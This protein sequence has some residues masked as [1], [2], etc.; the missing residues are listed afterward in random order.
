M[1][2]RYLSRDNEFVRFPYVF[3]KQRLTDNTKIQLH[4]VRIWKRKREC[5]PH[6]ESSPIKV[7]GFKLRSLLGTYG[8]WAVSVFKSAKTTVTRVICTT[9]M[10]EM[11]RRATNNESINHDFQYFEY[12][13]F[14]R[15]RKLYSY[16]D[17]IIGSEGLQLYSIA[18]RWR[19]LSMEPSL[20]CHIWY[21]T[22][23]RWQRSHP[24][25]Q[26][27]EVYSNGQPGVLRT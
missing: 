9:Y 10:S 2:R 24:K 15:S 8:H 17:D 3:W 19:P 13:L 1:S 25:K 5:F 12:C 26:L 11:G 18:R 27:N 23:I 21:D 7:K 4:I 20:S 14:S 16:V 6:M 22:G